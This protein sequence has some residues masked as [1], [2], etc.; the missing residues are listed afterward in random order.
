MK[1]K[2]DIAYIKSCKKEESIPT[3]AKVNLSIKSGGYKLKKKVAKPVME[4]ELQDKHYQLRQIGK[5]IRSIVIS[6]KSSLGL[7]LCNEIIH[8]KEI[9]T[10]GRLTSMKERHE[11]HLFLL[12]Q[13]KVSNSSVAIKCN[14]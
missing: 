7:I 1:L 8:Q 12:Q 6:L 3:F 5:Q 13:Q 10:R 4:T 11:K 2:T 14:T 9:A